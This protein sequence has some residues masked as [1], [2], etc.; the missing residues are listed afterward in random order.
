MD[1][2][3]AWAHRTLSKILDLIACNQ[4]AQRDDRS[5]FELI[6]LFHTHWANR[7]TNFFAN[8]IDFRKRIQKAC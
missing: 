2:P 4:S 5:E 1:A 6:L 3:L 8:P 7:M